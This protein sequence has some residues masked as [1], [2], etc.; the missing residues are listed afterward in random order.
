M[1]NIS[2]S[3]KEFEVPKGYRK[4]SLKGVNHPI[5]AKKGGPTAKQIKTKAS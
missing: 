2:E 1:K 3:P 4:Y 5:I